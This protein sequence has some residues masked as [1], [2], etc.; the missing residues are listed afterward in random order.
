M[1]A[2]FYWHNGRWCDCGHCG[3]VSDFNYE[4]QTP[5]PEQCDFVFGVWPCVLTLGHKGDHKGGY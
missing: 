5:P 4:Q 1:A 3:D 2:E